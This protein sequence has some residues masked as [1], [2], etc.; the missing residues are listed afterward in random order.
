[1]GE[2]FVQLLGNAEVTGTELNYPL[3]LMIKPVLMPVE[4]QDKGD[5]EQADDINPEDAAEYCPFFLCRKKSAHQ[6][7]LVIDI[8]RSGYCFPGSSILPA[9][10]QSI[11]RAR[12]INRGIQRLEMIGYVLYRYGSRNDAGKG[13][14]AVN[15]LSDYHSIL[16]LGKHAGP[17]NGDTA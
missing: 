13:V 17:V 16:A 10:Q 4:I 3:K 9:E 1:M 12:N 5:D 2:L 8:N 14:A 11:I 7:V 15:S 6:P